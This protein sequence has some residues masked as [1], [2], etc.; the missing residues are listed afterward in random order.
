MMTKVGM[1]EKVYPLLF[2][3]AVLSVSGVVNYQT[4]IEREGY[5]DR[6]RFKVEFLGN[7]EVA[8]QRI[9][10]AL[11]QMSEIRSGLDNDLLERPIVEMLD[12]GSL[13]FVPKTQSIVDRRRLY[14]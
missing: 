11:V 14:G 6:L 8:R 3:E 4:I 5:K 10:E 13:D 1:G 2:D 12:P 9:E 7:K